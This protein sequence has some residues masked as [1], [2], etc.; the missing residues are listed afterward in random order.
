M[1][2]STSTHAQTDD[3]AAILEASA[4]AIAE[5]PGFNAQFQMKGVGAA[6]F[7]DT[8]PSMNG[9]LFFGTHEELG[10]VIHCIGEAK[11]QQNAVPQ[12]IDIVLTSDRYL[13]T[14]HAKQEIYERPNNPD[15]PSLL[16]LRLWPTGFD[17]DIQTEEGGLA[18]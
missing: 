14:D 18:I 1:G 16:S 4:A 11:D 13:W 8:L 15:P 2:L 3:P 9:Q 6:L 10:R 12:A 5:V 17:R 7:A